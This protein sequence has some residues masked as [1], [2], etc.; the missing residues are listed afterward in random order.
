MKKIKNLLILVLAILFTGNVYAATATTSITGTNT[1]KVGKTTKIYIKLNASDLIE[2]VDVTYAASGNIQV[3]N[4]AIGSGLTQM[5]KNGNRY[6]LYAQSPIKSGSTILTLTVKGTKEGTGIITVSKMEATVSGGTVNGGSK[7]YNITVKPAKTAAEIKAEEEAA[8][9]REEERKAQEEANKKALEE[10]TKLVEAAEKSLNSEDYD[11]ALK[12]VSALTDSDDKTK[13]VE[14]LDK[15]KFDIEVNKVALDKCSN[16]E[17]NQTVCNCNNNDC[18][19]WITLSVILFV[20]LL[21]ETAYIIIR[22][23]NK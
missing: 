14:R 23:N 5:G 19:K 11:A 17:P 22:K 4:A 10:A 1:V 6:I 7:S 2:G 12:A 21:T 15:V 16:K 9:K 13:L 20:G 8:K 18:K 3:T